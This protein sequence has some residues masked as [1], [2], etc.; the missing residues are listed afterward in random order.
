M[1]L[2]M[3][4]VIFV[5]NWE[6]IQVQFVWHNF[7]QSTS[8]LKGDKTIHSYTLI[9]EVGYADYNDD[10]SW[11]QERRWWTTSP[12]TLKTSGNAASSQRFAIITMMFMMIMMIIM[13]KDIYDD[14]DN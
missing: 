7:L 9:I 3:I 4:E 13:I 12:T 2:M 10:K 8:I 11:S 1:T 6:T 5:M 14:H